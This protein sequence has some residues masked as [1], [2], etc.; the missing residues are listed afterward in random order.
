[1][2]AKKQVNFFQLLGQVTSNGMTRIYG[3]ATHHKKEEDIDALLVEELSKSSIRQKSNLIYK[4][5]P[6]VPQNPDISRK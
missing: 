6:S 2:E 3:M 4:N 5:P 1:M